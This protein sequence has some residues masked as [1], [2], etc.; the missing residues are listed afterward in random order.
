MKQKFPII[1]LEGDSYRVG[2]MHGTILSDR[3]SEVIR[4]Y[5]NLFGQDEEIIFEHAR[6]FQK[7]ITSFN[8]DYATEIEAIAE[9]AKVRP[10]WVY[11]LNARSEIINRFN[12]EC[13]ALYF[14]EKA[15]LGQ[16]WDWS[17]ELEDLA[18]ILLIKRVNQ[19]E[20]LMMTEPGIIGKI[21]FNSAGVGVC[22]NFLH[23]EGFKPYGVPV[24]VLLRSVLD[25]TSID[26][27]LQ[28]IEPVKQGKV[29]NFLLGDADGRYVDVEF[30]GDEM[31]LVEPKDL[32]FVHTNHYITHNINTDPEEFASSFKR[33]ERGAELLEDQPSDVED[34]KRILADKE[35]DDLPICRDYVPDELIGN[36]GTICSIIMDL[37]GRT[38][39][40]TRGNPFDNPYSKFSLD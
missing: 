31:W 13:T 25:S 35:V 36:V 2:K 22:L 27:A 16:N 5:H 15:L 29:A 19:P 3:I 39:H 6:E 23:M 34:M 37:R 32:G 24:H 38:M 12:N 14:R 10:E 28:A 1:R 8:P 18:V 21:G 11:A 30:G 7:A 9:G 33:Y 26:K 20:I 4:F 17:E 40:I